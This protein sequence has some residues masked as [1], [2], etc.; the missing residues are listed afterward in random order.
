MQVLN[1]DDDYEVHVCSACDAEFHLS[2]DQSQELVVEYCPFCGN[3]FE[4]EDDYEEDEE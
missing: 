3:N 2:Y 4:E 1:Y